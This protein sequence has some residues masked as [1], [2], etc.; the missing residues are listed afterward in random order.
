MRRVALREKQHARD[1]SDHRSRWY[2]AGEHLVGEHLAQMWVDV[3][4]VGEYLDGPEAVKKVDRP[5]RSPRARK[6]ATK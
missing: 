4:Q 2:A 5:A 6:K 3:L 1:I